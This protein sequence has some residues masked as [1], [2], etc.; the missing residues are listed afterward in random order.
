MPLGPSSPAELDQRIVV[1]SEEMGDF[2]NDRYS[3][4]VNYFFPG[5]T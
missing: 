2:V 1:E 3:D 4:L 5:V